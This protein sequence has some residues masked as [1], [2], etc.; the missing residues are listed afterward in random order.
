MINE[1]VTHGETNTINSLS[2][3][4]IEAFLRQAFE[5]NYE[6]LRLEGGHALTPYTKDIAFQQVL[7]YWQKLREVA[8]RVTDTEVKLTL[9]E[10]RTP[11]GRRYSIEG[12]VD[13]VREDER[14]IMYDI[15]THDADYVRGNIEQYEKQL[16]VY[17]HIWQ[18]LRGQPLD[19]TAI[20]ATAFPGELNEAIQ[21]GDEK[22][23]AREMA[24]WEPLVPV[25][26][27]QGHVEATIE[28]F[29]CVV[30]QIEGKAFQ[31][32][33]VERLKEKVPGMKAPFAVQVCRNCDARFSCKSY[34]NYALTAAS[35]RIEFKFSQFFSDGV[36]EPERAEWIAVNLAEAPP[37]TTDDGV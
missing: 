29:G 6:S 13:I 35:S 24:R 15:K 5:E 7:R 9:P 31:P 1:E 16:N 2:D 34:R 21:R 3:E 11:E 12:I 14:T 28:D 25:P 18:S 17:A 37:D 30:D 36:S 4:H 20:I 26:L 10:Q 8:E 22:L 33:P 32:P 19:E 27:D 23:I